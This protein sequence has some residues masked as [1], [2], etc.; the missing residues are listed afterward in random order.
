[1]LEERLLIRHLIYDD[2][3]VGN[4]DDND[5]DEL[6]WYKLNTNF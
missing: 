2:G 4:N 5:D 6:L 1:M 3:Y